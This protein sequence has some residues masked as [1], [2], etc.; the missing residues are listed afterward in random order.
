VWGIEYSRDD[1]PTTDLY[2]ELV[3]ELIAG[4]HNLNMMI[5]PVTMIPFA[6][7]PV[8]GTGFEFVQRGRVQMESMER[9]DQTAGF[10][11]HFDLGPATTWRS[12][13]L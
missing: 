2:Q 11:T 10:V 12:L 3:Q 5:F 1:T 4:E 8:R 6:R 7:R 13:P 9:P